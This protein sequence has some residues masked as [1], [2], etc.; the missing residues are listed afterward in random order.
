MS[1]R[2]KAVDGETSWDGYQ[3]EPRGLARRSQSADAE[4]N[5]S[6]PGLAKTLTRKVSGRWKRGGITGG[7]SEDGGKSS[8]VDQER[9]RTSLQERRV[10][11]FSN[12]RQGEEAKTRRSL[13]RSID[14][15]VDGAV[16]QDQQAS[17]RNGVPES[18]VETTSRSPPKIP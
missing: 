2:V 17:S 8:Q 7:R 13:G 18:G 1:E 16:T 6:K 9:D 11:S 12:A 15:F 4:G 14:I 3:W 10:G 5:G